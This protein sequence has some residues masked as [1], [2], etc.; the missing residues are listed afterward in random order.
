MADEF[1]YLFSPLKI[2]NMKVKNRIVITS[3]ETGTGFTREDSSSKEYIEYV[4]ARAKGGVGLIICG[5]VM[6]HPTSE[7]LD[8]C[9]P[10]HEGFRRKLSALKDAVHEHGA[11]ILFQICHTG[12]QAFSYTSMKPTMGFSALPSPD[13]R[14]MPHEMSVEEI[15]EMIDGYVAYA[16]DC[17]EAGLDGIELHGSHGYMLQQSWSWWANRRTDKYGEQMAFA[18]ELIDRVRAAVGPDLVISVR[19]SSDDLQPGGLNVENMTEI[20]QKLEATGKIDMINTSEGALY[21][22]Y[23]YAIGSSYIPLGAFTPLVGRIREGLKGIPILAVGRIKDHVQAERVLAEGHADLVG[24]V[25]A[26]IVDPEATNKAQSGRLEDI[27]KC[28]GCNN[29]IERIFK[30]HPLLCTQNA[31]IGKEDEMGRLTRAEVPKKILVVGAGPAGME[32][33]MVAA[34]RGHIVEIYEKASQ[35][36]GQIRFIC[37]DPQRLD[38]DDLRRYQIGQ[39]EKLSVP[40]HT[41]TEVTVDL[42]REKR[43]ECLVVATG[44]VP[45][46]LT[47]PLSEQ[48]V[49]GYDESIVMNLFDVYGNPEKVG[50]NVLIYD[51][52]G[53]IRGL[54][55]A[56]FLVQMGKTVEVA[57][58][59]FF[60]GM[61]SGYTYLPLFYD[62]LYRSGVKFTPSVVVKEVSGQEVELMNV[63][64]FQ[65]EK[66]SGVESLIPVLPQQAV[67]GLWRNL[68]GEIEEIH[69]IGDAASPR[70]LMQAV[71]D[72]FHLGRR[73]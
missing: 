10:A 73:I 37:R 60:A 3:H 68:K 7:A 65:V 41:E 13:L 22:T 56:L 46:D 62:K 58:E 27:R 6:A 49:P 50:S 54:S 59:L 15:E 55:T 21:T 4:R 31:I 71:H 33:A 43:P 19:I 17:K 2:G 48:L 34:Q 53:D 45:R 38:Y 42:L 9:A 47:F 69:V 67:D 70:N 32:F 30:L 11:K 24:M 39:L 5:G 51:R 63:F 44:S 26:H 25:R 28:I 72:G 36:G 35:P 66:R 61:E 20:A 14:E 52:L 12:R 18:Y 1:K 23:T 64:N 29:C 57:T 40:I 8:V 16:I